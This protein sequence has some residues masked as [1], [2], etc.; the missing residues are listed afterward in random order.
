MN[1]KRF[2]WVSL[3]VFLVFEIIDA[4]VHMVIL[5]KEYEA[6]RLMWRPDLMSKIWIFHVGSLVLAFLFTYIFVK[7]FENK[8]IAEGVRYGL[9]I[10]LFANIPYAFYEY[11]MLP[12][13]FSLCLQWFIYGMIE[14]IICGIFAAAIYKPKKM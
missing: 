14:Y 13:P 6:L 4:I 5:S 12:L 7:G 11:A 8:G 1:R 3:V 2:I 9:I 10:G